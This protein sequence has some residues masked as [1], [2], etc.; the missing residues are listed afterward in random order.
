[1]AYYSEDLLDEINNNINGSIEE[2]NQTLNNKLSNDDLELTD[3]ITTENSSLIAAINEVK[4]TAFTVYEGN[5]Q[6]YLDM[7]EDEK[8]FNMYIL[9]RNANLTEAQVLSLNEIINNDSQEEI[10]ADMTETQAIEKTE[11]IIGGTE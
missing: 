2:I 5:E 3:L 4:R 1:M 9:E 10:I 11:E 8:T 6:D 7:T